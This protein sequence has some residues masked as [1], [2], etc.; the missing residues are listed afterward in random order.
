MTLLPLISLRYALSQ[1]AAALAIDIEESV[2][3]SNGT[4][5]SMRV[6]QH[7]VQRRNDAKPLQHE[8]KGK[9]WWT[10]LIAH[11]IFWSL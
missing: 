3:V 5:A 8:P 1:G 11:E 7:Q 10:Y 2:H 4:V 9:S 6:S